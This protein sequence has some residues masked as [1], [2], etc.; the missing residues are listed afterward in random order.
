MIT[1]K[2]QESFIKK[3]KSSL[4]HENEF[5]D[6][7]G[8]YLSYLIDH[9]EY[10]IKIYA[11]VLN[12]G[13]QLAN[14]NMIEAS[15]ADIGA[16]N[17]MLGIFAK[18]CG[19]KDVYINDIDKDFFEASKK[20]SAQLS[21]FPTDF[22]EGDAVDIYNYFRNQKAPDIIVGTDMIE[23]VYS[24]EKFFDALF[25][26]IGIKAVV[27]TTA[28]NPA[29][30]WRVRQLRKIQF[31]DEYKG[32][33]PGEYLLYGG[34]A[35]K[36]FVE[37]RKEIIKKLNHFPEAELCLMAKRTRGLD[38]ADIENAVKI[39]VQTGKF[40]TPPKDKFNTCNP[41]TGS[42][43]ERIV[44]IKFY[45]HLL[46]KHDCTVAIDP[47]FYDSWKSGLK[48]FI[49]KWANILVPIL[50]KYIAPFIIISAKKIDS[51]K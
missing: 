13:L 18:Y 33:Y 47:G 48:G 26:C 17:G 1:T 49:L 45:E 16:G 28:C 4:I 19:F 2:H 34:E 42:W 46:V 21:V 8:I 31:N 14:I 25:S 5:K 29:N 3:L 20:L 40:P 32:G 24:L 7:P 36:P 39:Y 9:I 6:Y 23:H 11:A 38:K 30:I 15:V 41:L 27:F 35:T 22:I 50:G 51:G 43:S 10:F 44:P 37:I 12:K